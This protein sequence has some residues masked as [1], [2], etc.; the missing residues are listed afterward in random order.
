MNVYELILGIVTLIFSAIITPV[1][2]YIL[3]KKSNAK[4]DTVEKK[5]DANFEQ[6]NGHF[7][8]LLEMKKAEG[9]A[10]EKAKHKSP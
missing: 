8:K 3:N 5:L 2:I 4:V 9:K 6:A 10:E 1:M 7:S